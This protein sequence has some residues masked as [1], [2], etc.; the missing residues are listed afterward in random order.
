MAVPSFPGMNPYLESPH[1]WLEVHAKL[2]SEIA[3]TL[4]QKISPSYHAHIAKRAC[5]IT[6]PT[7]CKITE[8]YI[9]IKAPAADTVITVIEVLSSTSKRLAEGRKEYLSI[10]EQLL[11]SNAHL[12]EIDLLRQGESMPAKN[13]EFSDYQILVSRA[14][15][16]PEIKQY[17]FDL[18]QPIP[19]VLIPLNNSGD[20][21]KEQIAEPLLDIKVLLDKVCADTGIE[22]SINYDVQPQ[23]PMSPAYF[24]WVRSLPKT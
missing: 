6:L 7:R 19:Q 3:N 4:N 23:P 16:R 2:I 1:R 11:K 8:V 9:E 17:A 14:E 24:E 20:V 15:H 18:P 5:K 13:T 21:E 22:E 10:R 12:V